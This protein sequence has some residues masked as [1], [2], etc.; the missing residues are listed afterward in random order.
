MRGGVWIAVILLSLV[1]LG[2][3]G[4]VRAERQEYKSVGTVKLVNTYRLGNSLFVDY[5]MDGKSRTAKVFCDDY[6]PERG[7]WVKISVLY[8]GNRRADDENVDDAQCVVPRK[9]RP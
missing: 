6:T 5:E 9:R 1:G 3:L 7:D 8:E 2:C 4:P